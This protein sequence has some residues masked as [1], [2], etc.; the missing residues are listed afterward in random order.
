MDLPL[1]GNDFRRSQEAKGFHCWNGRKIQDGSACLEGSR[2]DAGAN[3]RWGC[4]PG[5][6]ALLRRSG[7][8]PSRAEAGTGSRTNHPRYS[9][10]LPE[11]DQSTHP[12]QVGRYVSARRS[13]RLGTGLAAQAHSLTN[14]Q[15][16]HPITD[17]PSLRQGHDLGTD[18][19]RS[20]PD[21]LGRSE[22][23]QQAQETSAHSPGKGRLANTRRI[24]T[25]PSNH[26]ADCAV[27]RFADQRNPW[28][29]L[30]G[31]RFREGGC[32]DPAISGRQTTQQ[33][34]DRVFAGRSPARTGLHSGVEGMASAMSRVRGTMAISQ[35]GDWPTLARRFD[36]CRLF[37]TDGSAIGT[38]KNR[39]PLVPPH[40]PCV[41][42]RNWS[43][44]GRAAE[45]HATR[46]HFHHDGPVWQC[47]D[48]SQ[49][50]SQ[51]ASGAKTL[52]KN[53]W[54]RASFHS[55]NKGNCAAVSLYWTVLDSRS[56]LTLV[57]NSMIP[58]VAG[59]GFEPPT[60]GL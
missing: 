39:I 26:R 10:L 34:E 56:T 60:F 19:C 37:G 21:G 11:H 36:S 48:G 59:G 52:E 45:A 43:A 9:C 4:C 25:A 32:S 42:G 35:S 55:I 31:L 22:G 28:V 58:L 33:V 30:D 8:F 24:G 38:W 1:V 16:P 3:Q 41:A 54:Q 12:S 17:V 14:I 27:L 46:A 51:S 20:E 29:A 5:T 40:V 53:G 18:R 23:H 47:I 6:S 2:R 44:R 13:P 50:Q 57:R 7:P 15:R 49:A